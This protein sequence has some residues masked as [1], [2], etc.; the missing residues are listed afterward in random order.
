MNTPT[1]IV[2]IVALI[3][4]GLSSAMAEP[5]DTELI[6]L[7][8]V[9]GSMRANDPDNLR[10]SAVRLVSE[11][12]PQEATAGIWTFGEKVE[13]IIAPSRVDKQWK[14]D[15]SRATKRVHSRG[16]FTNIEAALDVATDDWG[17]TS[18]DSSERSSDTQTP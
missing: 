17:T 9:S 7:I 1:K 16:Q 14:A 18:Q 15:A 2:T 3:I 5:V 8:D 13:Q 4:S 10:K 11:L 12:M 6:I